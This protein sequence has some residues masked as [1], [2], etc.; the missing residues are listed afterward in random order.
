MMP[1]VGARVDSSEN[2][3]GENYEGEKQERVKC[4]FTDP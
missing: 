3:M 1:T 4:V 2:D